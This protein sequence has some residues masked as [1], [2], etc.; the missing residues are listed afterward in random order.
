[1]DTWEDSELPV[2]LPPTHEIIIDL[3][4]PHPLWRWLLRQRPLK[5]QFA[6]ITITTPRLLI[7]GDWLKIGPIEF[8]VLGVVFTDD[9]QPPFVRLLAF[10]RNKLV[11]RTAFDNSLDRTLATTLIYWVPVRNWRDPDNG[12]LA[13]VPQPRVLKIA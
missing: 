3:A 7:A 11:L 2:T 13:D 6:K 1:M 4:F 12:M 10:G 9:G 8:K 5:R